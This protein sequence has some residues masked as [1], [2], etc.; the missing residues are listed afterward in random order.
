VKAKIRIKGPATERG[1]RGL[2]KERATALAERRRN[3]TT[4]KPARTRVRKRTGRAGTSPWRSC[5]CRCGRMGEYR[6][7]AQKTGREKRNKSGGKAPARVHRSFESILGDDWMRDE[8]AHVTR[9]K[10]VLP[11]SINLFRAGL[12]LNHSGWAGIC[13][14]RTSSVAEDDIAEGWVCERQVRSISLERSK[15]CE[16]REQVKGRQMK[17]WLAWVV[18]LIRSRLYILIVHRLVEGDAESAITSEGAG[19][20][21]RGSM[22]CSPNSDVAASRGGFAAVCLFGR[23][24]WG[25]T[26]RPWGSRSGRSCWMP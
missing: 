16:G 10:T 1:D 26:S 4:E 21:A 22:Q 11:F 13:D 12:T 23:G 5:S 19:R 25:K 7:R 8:A 14:Q 9:A 2:E 24:P 6:E 15:G 18:P 3:K 20:R 17:D